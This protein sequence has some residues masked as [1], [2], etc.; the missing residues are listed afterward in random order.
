M[1]HRGAM[2]DARYS[3]RSDELSREGSRKVVLVKLEIKRLE[4]E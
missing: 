1:V 3:E 4:E 2:M